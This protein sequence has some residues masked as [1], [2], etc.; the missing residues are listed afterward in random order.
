MS[1]THLG[2]GSE[3]SLIYNSVMSSAAVVEFSKLSEDATMVFITES[4]HYKLGVQR[5]LDFIFTQVQLILTSLG[6]P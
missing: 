1:T 6:K 2:M 3:M 4:L 5:Q